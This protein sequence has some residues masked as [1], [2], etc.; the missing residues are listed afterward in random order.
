M[1]G[2]YYRRLDP[3]D[4]DLDMEIKDE[5]GVSLS[6]IIQG[7]R[8]VRFRYEYDFGDGWLHEIVFERIVGREPRVTYPRC[9]EGARACPPEVVGGPLGYGNFLEAIADPS[10]EDHEWMKEWIG[11]KLDPERFDVKKVNRELR[12]IWADLFPRETRS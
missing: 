11:E 9:V 8:K 12:R 2:E 7:D 10:H 3:D 6:Q 4:D 5:Q 1:N